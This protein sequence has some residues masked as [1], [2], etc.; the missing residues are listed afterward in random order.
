MDDLRPLDNRLIREIRSQ[1]E[2][3]QVAT[4]AV[5]NY[6]GD[7]YTL[8]PSLYTVVANNIVQTNASEIVRWQVGD[9]MMARQGG[10]D[11]TFFVI[12]VDRVSNRITVSGGTNFTLTVA[13]IEGLKIAPVR[14]IPANF[15]STY[16]FNPNLSL[17][18]GGVT[19]INYIQREFSVQ[20][21]ICTVYLSVLFDITAGS[22]EAMIDLPIQGYNLG[23]ASS[24]YL[25]P[26]LTLGD[27][28]NPS[29]GFVSSLSGSTYTSAVVTCG[30]SE[31]FDFQ[32]NISTQFSYKII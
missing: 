18:F 29:T 20:G 28:F 7:S 32:G 15:P 17:I 21:D 3:Q 30:N 8:T 26:A 11:K 2:Q 27:S 25:G 13:V 23:S 19:N 1:Q 22:P 10:T 6:L 9:R 24:V 31:L 5:Q 16:T 4:T 12:G 14:I